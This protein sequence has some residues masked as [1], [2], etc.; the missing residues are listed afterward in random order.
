MKDE[1]FGPILPIISYHDETDLKKIISTYEKPLALYVFSNDKNFAERMI[2]NF[3]FGGGCVNDCMIHFANKRLPFG[4][5][6]KSGYG[7]ELA[8]EGIKEFVNIKTV[9]INRL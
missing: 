8:I 6:K 9:V 5:V 4:G 1:I 7:R 3:S 2:I